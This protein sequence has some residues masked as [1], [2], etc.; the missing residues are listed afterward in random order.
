MK[1]TLI[2]KLILVVLVA[3]MVGACC[4]FGG[5]LVDG[6]EIELKAAARWAG[7]IPPA[8]SSA[9]VDFYV[10]AESVGSWNLIAPDLTYPVD[11]AGVL[12]DTFRL[13]YEVPINGEHVTYRYELDLTVAGVTYLAA[14]YPDALTCES[15]VWWWYFA[16][17]LFCSE[18]AR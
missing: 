15:G 18:G 14:D 9:T 1:G 11:A 17:R 6:P 12:V 5:E 3:L 10:L 2:M 7:E 13:D 16:G 4:S 8:G